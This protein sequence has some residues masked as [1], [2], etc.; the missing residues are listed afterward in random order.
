MEYILIFVFK[1]CIEI[2]LSYAYSVSLERWTITSGS[3][4]RRL[5]FPLDYNNDCTLRN[6]VSYKQIFLNE[7]SGSGLLLQE[8]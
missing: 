5:Y 4:Y 2:V 6:C 7:K 3:R 8:A 1:I